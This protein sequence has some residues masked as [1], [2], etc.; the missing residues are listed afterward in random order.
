MTPALEPTIQSLPLWEPTKRVALWAQPGHSQLTPLQGMSSAGQGHWEL[1]GWQRWISH[2]WAAVSQIHEE[3][4]VLSIWHRDTQL[5]IWYPEFTQC[6]VALMLWA[7]EPN[8][9][10][11]SHSPQGKPLQCSQEQISFESAL[12]GRKRSEEAQRLTSIWDMSKR[13]EQQECLI[14]R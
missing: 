4:G 9:M 6:Y 3:E 10:L 2:K 11:R 13:K 12:E 5:S 1:G 14:Q 7:G 8:V